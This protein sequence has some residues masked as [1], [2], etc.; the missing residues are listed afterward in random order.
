[1]EKINNIEK[2]I[3]RKAVTLPDQAGRDTVV[4]K[5]QEALDI[6]SE[7]NMSPY[8]IY[9][10][11]LKKKILPYRYIRNLSSITIDEQLE[12]LE[13]R[14]GI[15]GAGGLG[16]QIIVLLARLGIG[17]LAVIDHD[18][19]DETNL[20]RQALSAID[21][22][23]KSKAETAKVAISKINP[24]VNVTAFQTR[25]DSSN[26]KNILTDSDVIVDAL[27]NVSDRFILEDFAKNFGIPLVHGAVAGFE[28]QLMTIFPDDAGMESIYGKD[29]PSTSPEKSPVS[30]LGVPAVTPAI[31]ASF[32]VIEVMKIILK[33]ENL[34]RNMLVYMDLEK[35]ESRKLRFK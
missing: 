8:D 19:F 20:N 34:L 21:V 9:R 7:Y 29:R 3:S 32:Q 17:N 1:M 25:L 30:I 26:A 35:C 31:I 13:S 27:D 33:K 15:I 24:A 10:A 23:G 22:I 14:I 6:A 12:L 16:G 11:A 4:I 28:G 5:E 2:E 18:V